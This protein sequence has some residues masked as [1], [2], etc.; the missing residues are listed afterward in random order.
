[1]KQLENPTKVAKNLILLVRFLGWGGGD[2]YKKW[3]K[4]FFVGS[5]LMEWIVFA[6]NLLR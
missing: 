6:V 5:F 1:M 4:C 2:S 3:E